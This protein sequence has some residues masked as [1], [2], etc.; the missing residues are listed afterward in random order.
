MGMLI[1]LILL[2]LTAVLLI[3]CRKENVPSE[4]ESSMVTIPFYR[5]GVFLSRKVSEDEKLSNMLL[6]KNSERMYLLNPGKDVRRSSEIHLI[7]KISGSLIFLTAGIMLASVMFIK[8]ENSTLLKNGNALARREFEKGDYTAL[9]DVNVDGELFENER[10][11]V[12]ERLYNEEELKAMMPDFKKELEAIL[13]RKNKTPDKI[14]HD[15]DPQSDIDGYPFKVEWDF[16]NDLISRDGTLKDDLQ[17]GTLTEATADISYG[18]YRESYTIPLMIYPKALSRHEE[19]HR[20]LTEALEKASEKSSTDKELILPEQTEDIEI[21]WSEKKK[22]NTMLFLITAAAVAAAMFMAPDKD[23]DKKV[24]ERDEQMLMDY[25]EVVSKLSIYI[26]AGMTVRMAWKKITDEYVQR[27][28]KGEKRH[29]I[30]EEM[31]LAAYEMESGT[32][33]LVAYRHFSKRCRVQKYVKLVSLLE[34]SIKLGAKNFLGALKEEAD[35]AVRNSRA[36]VKR[37]GEEA[38][39]KLLLPMMLMLLIVMVVII[40][41]AFMTM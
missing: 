25:P 28:N 20:I 39:T 5:A 41:P 23:L 27:V 32:G 22:D 12:L 24:K 10:V 9:L 4:I 13:L 1:C 2:V 35:D 40:V 14:D 21:R 26:G 29:F 11:E 37:K 19:M 8:N 17:A 36:A 16:D 3:L 30:Y 38:G 18:D 15:L 7:K 6:Q 34:Q 31:R 33:E